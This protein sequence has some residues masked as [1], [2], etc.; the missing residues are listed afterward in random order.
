MALPNIKDR[1]IDEIEDG[2][3]EEGRFF[4]HLKAGF[5]WG[6]DPYN[7]IRSRSFGSRKE[8]LEALKDV[9]PAKE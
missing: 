9:K 2:G 4:V 7:V 3:M 8:V 1:R 5:D 6:T